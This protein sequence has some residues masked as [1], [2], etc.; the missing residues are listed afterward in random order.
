MKLAK[1]IA[2]I[3][4]IV[5]GVLLFLYNS[6]WCLFV[7]TFDGYKLVAWWFICLIPNCFLAFVPA[8][9]LGDQ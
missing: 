1:S 8:F 5:I 7:S 2:C 9:Y 3:I 4:I 6:W